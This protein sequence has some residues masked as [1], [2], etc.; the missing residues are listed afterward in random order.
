[1]RRLHSSWSSSIRAIF[2]YVFTLIFSFSLYLSHTHTHTHTHLSRS[3]CLSLF[4]HTNMHIHAHTRTTC[5]TTIQHLVLMYKGHLQGYM[6][7]HLSL[8]LSLS[9]S[10][11]HQY[12]PSSTAYCIWSVISPISKLN[13]LF[14]SSRL[15]CRV[16][17]KRD[18]FD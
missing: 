9:L 10:I 13:R 4:S 3:L 8:S 18:Q 7:T 11:T 6:H 16:P 5:A 15:F 12:T 2:R 17:L 1:M 14:R